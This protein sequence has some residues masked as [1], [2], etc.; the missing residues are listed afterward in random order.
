MSSFVIPNLPRLVREMGSLYSVWND[1]TQWIMPEA[2]FYLRD[3]SRTR[4][5]P[6]FNTPMRTHRPFDKS[7]RPQRGR[8]WSGCYG[9]VYSAAAPGGGPAGCRGWAIWEII[10]QPREAGSQVG[11]LRQALYPSSRSNGALIVLLK[12]KCP[13]R[14]RLWTPGEARALPDAR[15]DGNLPRL[16]GGELT[17]PSL[18][19]SRLSGISPRRAPRSPRLLC[20]SMPRLPPRCRQFTGTAEGLGPLVKCASIGRGDHLLRPVRFEAFV[21]GGQAIDGNVAGSL[22]VWSP[23]SDAIGSPSSRCEPSGSP[24]VRR[25]P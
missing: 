12:T 22:F 2:A 9:I 8:I 6:T 11:K 25:T 21:G 20:M 10:V 18:T 15:Y 3:A 14:L 16:F 13:S 1:C 7:G 23:T 5:K 17:P 19:S 4:G 24:V